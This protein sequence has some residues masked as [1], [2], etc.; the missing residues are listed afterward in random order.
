MICKIF[1]HKWEVYTYIPAHGYYSI[2]YE[3]AGHC[4]RC[5]TDTHEIRQQAQGR[6]V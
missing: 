1:G 2:D 6:T 4:K 3:Q 5:D